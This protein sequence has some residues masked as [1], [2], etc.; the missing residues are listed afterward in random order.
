MAEIMGGDL[1]RYAHWARARVGRLLAV[2]LALVIYFLLLSSEVFRF[3]PRHVSNFILL[4]GFSSLVALLFLAV[5]ALVWLY[6]RDRRVALLL[7][8][9]CVAMMVTFAGETGSVYND[10]LSSL[11]VFVS[12]GLA[13]SLFAALLL[14]FPRDYFSAGLRSGNRPGRR[15]SSFLLRG[16][17][18][19]LALTV[20]DDC[21]ETLSFFQLLPKPMWI[22][23]VEFI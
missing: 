7:F 16:Y 21:R 11:I 23:T 18:I 2:V 4:F 3:L 14:F 20:L 1:M 19:V 9:F 8:G 5:G 10:P 12:S 22:E 15:Y 6:A 17:A 13:L